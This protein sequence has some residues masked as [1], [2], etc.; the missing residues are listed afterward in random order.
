MRNKSAHQASRTRRDNAITV[1][2]PRLVRGLF[3]SSNSSPNKDRQPAALEPTSPTL[4]SLSSS[5]HNTSKV[6]INGK[7]QYPRG[8]LALTRN[9]RNTKSYGFLERRSR[10]EENMSPTFELGLSPKFRPPSRQS[11]AFPQHL[12]TNVGHTFGGPR[13]RVAQKQGGSTS[14]DQA[15]STKEH[16]VNTKKDL[17]AQKRPPSRGKVPWQGKG[18]SLEIPN[19]SVDNDGKSGNKKPINMPPHRALWFQK[20]AK[21]LPWPLFL[22]N[23]NRNC[24]VEI[25]NIRSK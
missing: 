1:S 14:K 21:S 15:N 5:G 12:D 19:Q 20:D 23:I 6:Q 2:D 17:A 11:K 13:S 18:L 25:N 3:R 4:S 22:E 7:S 8:A 10:P 9:S 24:P 16:I